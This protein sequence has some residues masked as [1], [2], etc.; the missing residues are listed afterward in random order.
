MMPFLQRSTQSREM[1]GEEEGQFTKYEREGG[2]HNECGAA[3]A[4][5]ARTKVV[6]TSPD[7]QSPLS[8]F[9]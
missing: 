2:G 9:C 8:L 5:A 4:A 1:K 3:V 6:P 7:P